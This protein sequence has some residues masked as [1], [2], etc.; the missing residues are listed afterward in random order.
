MSTEDYRNYIAALG[1]Q[2]HTV[3]L[4]W[5]GEPLL[6]THLPEMVRIARSAGMF[7]VVSTNAQL[8]TEEMA[9]RLVNAGLHRLIVSI[10]GLSQESYSAYRTGGSLE[11]A[12]AGLKAVHEAKK[13]VGKRLFP[14]VELQ[15]LRLRSNEHEWS[16][17]RHNYRR[18]GADRLVFKTAQFYNY[19][20]G[21]ALMPTDERYSRYRL[22][23]DGQYHLKR[24]VRNRCRR[25]WNSCV[26]GVDGTVY[27]CCY[28][29]EHQFPLGNL[30]TQTMAEIW[31][32]EKANRF[33]RMILSDAAKVNMCTNCAP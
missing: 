16:T 9:E 19:A 8:L 22:G 33:R 26:I 4:F 13:R 29:K 12:L 11:L 28:D 24:T 7:T 3:Q 14:I 30:K 31:H 18:L 6:N 23:E 17:L 2:V 32:G 27:P 5:Q 20:E 25:L 1:P 15:M 21:D 10:D